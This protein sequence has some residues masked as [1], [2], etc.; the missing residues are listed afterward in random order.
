MMKILLLMIVGY[1][2][3]FHTDNGNDVLSHKIDQHIC[4]LKFLKQELRVLWSPIARKGGT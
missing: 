1:R 2:Y 4:V 3:V